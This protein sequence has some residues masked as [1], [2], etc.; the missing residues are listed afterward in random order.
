MKW[1]DCK[2]CRK[3]V[4]GQSHPII[5]AKFVGVC[6]SGGCYCKPGLVWDEQLKIC[7]DEKNCKKQDAIIIRGKSEKNVYYVDV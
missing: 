3:V 1:Y 4:C 7:V 6:N 5:C 2:P